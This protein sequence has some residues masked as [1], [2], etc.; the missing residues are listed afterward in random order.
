MATEIN[1]KGEDISP[2]KDGGILKEIIKKGYSNEKPITNDKVFVHYVGTLLDGTKFDSSRDRNQKFEFEL[3]KGSVIKAWDIGVATMERG[4]ICRL[5]CKSEYAYGENGSGDKIGPNATLIFE[6]ELF[7]FMGEDISEGKDQSVIRRIFTKGEGWAK[8]SDGS[9]VDISLKGTHENRIFDE[10][11]LKF[12]VGEGLLKDIPEGIEYGVT[13]MTKGEKSQLKLKSKAI[14]GLEKFN[15]PKNAHVE[16]I[17]TLHDF[18]K[19]VDKWSIADAE[20]IQESEKLKKRAAEL[21]KD[22]HYRIACKKYKAIIEYLKTDNYDSE[23]DKN[24][25]RELKLATHSNMALCCLK[26]GEYAQCIR[27]CDSALELDSKNEKCFF[28]RGQ[29]YLAMLDYNE[30]IKDFQQVLKLNPSNTAA[31]QH[32]QT[33]REQIKAYQHQEKQLY[34]KIFSKMATNN[35]KTGDQATNGDTKQNKDETATSN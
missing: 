21:I 34:A 20:K 11:K 6:I 1:L 2:A 13:R 31:T 15:I 23:K 4:E 12:T 29:S 22:G 24:K 18:E 14:D 28:R 35:E 7:D 33:C 19:G 17:V 30:A 26:L 16:Y 32:I 3:G 25:V 8:P 27:A 10:R 5:I 9:I